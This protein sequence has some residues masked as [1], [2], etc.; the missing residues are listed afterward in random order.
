MRSLST[1]V[2]AN[3]GG[4]GWIALL[5]IVTVPIYLRL[6][7]PQSYGLV[8]LYAT[9]QSVLLVLDLGITPMLS[10][11]VAR[12]GA[13]PE[14]RAS[15]RPLVL[16]WGVLYLGLTALLAVVLLAAAEPATR[17]W[18]RGSAIPPAS[19]ASYA[20]Q[21]VVLACLQFPVSLA[22]GVLTGLERQVEAN[23]M[24][25]AA[26]TLAAGGAILLLAMWAPTLSLFFTWQIAI[27]VLQ[28]GV[29]AELVLRHL[30]P[31]PFR[32]ARQLVLQSWG[33]AAGMAG[34]SA[35]SLLFT[36][37][38]RLVLSTL[39]PLDAFAYYCV[40]Y[41]GAR[42]LFVL[43]TPVFGP[44]FARFSALAVSGD[45][46]A[47]SNLYHQSTQALAVTILP[48]AA[49]A[50]AFAPEILRAWTHDER[51]VASASAT[52]AMLVLGNAIGGLMHVPYALQLSHGWTRIALGVSI[53]M[54]VVFVPAVAIACR[55]YGSAGAAAVWLVLNLGYMLVT[56][57]LTHRRL[58]KHEAFRWLVRD[59]ALPGVVAIM[60][61]F[62]GRMLVPAMHPAGVLWAALFAGIGGL[63]ALGGASDLR[64]W[65]AGAWRSYRT[66]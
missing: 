1:N 8:G 40:A 54:L 49:A 28:A 2:F 12:L 65:L 51:A 4:Q 57:P 10:R 25:A 53:A 61:V 27:A 56:V 30:P 19:L 21:M 18:L 39:L 24:R 62:A 36:Q 52:F 48:V 42:G 38:D 60:V 66:A 55:H 16:T 33:F 47:L 46:A 37:S 59:T 3:L 34:L 11:E 44:L 22:T 50:A 58:L 20:R 13:Q 7:G 15:L 63:A 6:L 45:E 29:A 31:A 17:W 35:T 14:M 64:G 41:T 23:L 26:A 9:L 43:V 32:F 5:Q